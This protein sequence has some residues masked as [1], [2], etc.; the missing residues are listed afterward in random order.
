ME[1]LM[2]AVLNFW[3]LLLQHYYK[4]FYTFFGEVNRNESP[5]GVFVKTAQKVACAYCVLAII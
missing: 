4:H 3:G 1:E 2:L 5:D